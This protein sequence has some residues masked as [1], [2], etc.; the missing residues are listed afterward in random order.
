[1]GSNPIV[2]KSWRKRFIGHAAML[3]TFLAPS[4]AL[5][6]VSATL[7][8]APV[9]VT[10]YV[11]E[12]GVPTISIPQGTLNTIR[13]GSGTGTGTD[14]ST[15]ASS[16]DVLET[17]LAQSWGTSAIADAQ[18]LGLNPSAL[19]ATCVIESGCG[20]DVGDGSGA[21]GVFQM[22]PAAFQEGLQT[23]LAADPSLASEIVQGSA[24]M[25]DPTTEAIAASG[26]LIEANQGLENAGISDPT[27]LDAR[28]VY[29]FGPTNGVALAT[30]DP[31]ELVADA[32]PNVSQATLSANGISPGETVAEYQASVTSK[33]G[34]AASQTVL[35][36]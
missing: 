32:M 26:Y 4:L 18:A 5:A 35:G 29:N 14:G 11:S 16:S 22:Y 24:G 20:A 2:G 12:P 1:M 8:G 25:N 3:P 34:N 9:Q 30:A 28:A 17:M 7:D 21:Q 10:P 31:S 13:N 36:T 6:Q 33:I 19:A 23:A 15:S 27:V